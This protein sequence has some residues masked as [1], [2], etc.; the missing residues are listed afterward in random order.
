M[1][2]ARSDLEVTGARNTKIVCSHYEPEE[3][4]RVYDTMPCVI[5]CHGNSSCSLEAIDLV[6]SLLKAGMTLFCFDFP[7]CG[8]SDGEYISL[9]WYEKDE[10]QVIID[11]V[12]S[13]RKVSAVGL[14]G[15]SMGAATSLL[16]A[17]RDP[18]IGALVLDSPFSD[19]R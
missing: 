12:R 9:G 16:H 14:W 4:Q 3:S 8:R 11:Y 15:R 19:L 13:S 5:Y 1:T 2:V 7:G 18:S 17:S 10:I 6:P